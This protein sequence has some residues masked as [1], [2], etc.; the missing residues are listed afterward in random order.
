MVRRVLVA[1]VVFVGAASIPA[2]AA[3]RASILGGERI[4]LPSKVMGEERAIFVSLPES[5]ARSARRYPVLYLTDAD[6]QFVHTRATAAFL[7]RNGLMPEIIIVAVT[8]PDRVRDLYASRADFVES[9]RTIHFPTSGSADLFLEFFERELIPW[10][11]ATYRTAPLRI[12]AG[13][14]A[15]GNFALHA[16]RTKPG[17]FQAVIAA[18]P[19]LAWDDRKELK[20]LLPFLLSADVKARTLFFT[21]ADEGPGMKA[22]LDAVAAAL[23]SRKDGSL[24]W[25]AAAY[26][27]ESHDSV[28]LKSYYDAIRMIFAGWSFPRDPKTHLLKGSLDDV[29][30]HY[31]KLGERLGFPLLPPEATVNELGYQH[32]NMENLV[33]SIATFRYNTELYPESANVWDSL[34]D[35]L[36]R[37]GEKDEALAS[38]RKAVSLAEANGDPNLEAFRKHVARLGGLAKPDAK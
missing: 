23:R 28:V 38:Y 21:S 24:R 37:A 34:G 26:P 31:A 33:P 12:L 6:W 18:S 36:D 19:W 3:S 5:Y 15:G 14:S 27:D 8:N 25:G 13:H 9:G 7:A 17:L 20:Q 10:T 35:A 30:T 22:D 1:A 16:M 32:L 11:E 29:K 4:T 2:T